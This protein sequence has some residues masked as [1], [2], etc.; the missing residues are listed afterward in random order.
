MSSS[1]AWCVVLPTENNYLPDQLKRK[2]SRRLWNTDGSCGDGRVTV[3]RD[4]IPY[5]EGLRD[6]G[7][8]GAEELI[9]LIQK[10]EYI[11]LWH[12]Y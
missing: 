6:C 8:D 4:L 2:L 11:E 9:D 12:E 5:L 1:L 10:H 3:G 7:I